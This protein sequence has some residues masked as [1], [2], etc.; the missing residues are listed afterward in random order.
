ML[1]TLLAI[2]IHHQNW[3][4]ILRIQPKFQSNH[5]FLMKHQILQFWKP[6]YQYV[7]CERFMKWLRYYLTVQMKCHADEMPCRCYGSRLQYLNEDHTF[8]APWV[9]TYCPLHTLNL[10]ALM[11]NAG[12]VT[13]EVS[14]LRD[15][16]YPC[17]GSMLMSDPL[18]STQVLLN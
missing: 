8:R 9:E 10:S 12:E 11:I 2:Y 7:A 16:L 5:S 6:S 17:I 3:M 1:I 15:Y 4:P 14:D 13:V 18:G